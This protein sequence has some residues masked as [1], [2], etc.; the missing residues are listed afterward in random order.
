[1]SMKRRKLMDTSQTSINLGTSFATYVDELRAAWRTEEVTLRAQLCMKAMEKLLL[2]TDETWLA[3]IDDLASS[4]G[5]KELYRDP[6]FG[7][8]QKA[9]SYS[10]DH[11]TPPHGHGEGGW[12]VYGVQRGSV[13]IATYEP[14]GDKSES[15]KLV[16]SKC[17]TQGMAQSYLPG[18]LHSTRT[19]T[20]EAESSHG[21]I[22]L[23]FLSEDLSKVKRS[24]YRW[25]DVLTSTK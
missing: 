5:A 6:S 11:A 7:F 18:E 19:M 14:T 3:F 25:E 9:H 20:T 16:E 12:V 4:P 21:T 8:V 22:V 1:M 2:T 13:E 10:L 15:V 24:R 23:R 17:M